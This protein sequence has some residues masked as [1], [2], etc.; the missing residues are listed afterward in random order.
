M[1]LSRCFY[2]VSLF[3]HCQMNMRHCYQMAQLVAEEMGLNRDGILHPIQHQETNLR[4]NFFLKIHLLVT[5]RNF[6]FALLAPRHSRKTNFFAQDYPTVGPISNKM[7]NSGK[8]L[9]IFGYY[10][11]CINTR[12]RAI[13]NNEINS[14]VKRPLFGGSSVVV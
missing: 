7:Q 6:F 13:K 1:I 14:K 12:K 3:S 5:P 9:N 10:C 11:V 8:Q 2:L 4:V